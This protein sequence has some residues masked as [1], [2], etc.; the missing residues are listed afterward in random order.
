[1]NPFIHV[2]FQ[3]CVNSI[4]SKCYFRLSFIICL[5]WHMLVCSQCNSF[6]LK[7]VVQMTSDI[8]TALPCWGRLI[9]FT[10]A[11]RSYAYYPP[12]LTQ[13][14]PLQP[15]CDASI[16]MDPVCSKHAYESFPVLK[17][18]KQ[19]FVL[20]L[21]YLIAYIAKSCMSINIKSR[22]YVYGIWQYK[23]LSVI[24]HF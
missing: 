18:K 14:W 17:N 1:M 20:Y 24:Q 4:C 16:V 22:Y 3:L 8:F 9:Y 7:S 6:I 11:H 13:H 5:H 12:N 21:G 19:Q 10:V 23:L 2:L 15:L